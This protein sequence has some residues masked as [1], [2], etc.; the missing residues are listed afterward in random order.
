MRCRR[1]PFS[2][3]D[4]KL[5]LI[6]PFSLAKLGSALRG[7]TLLCLAALSLTL[8]SGCDSRQPALET[9][10]PPQEEIVADPVPQEPVT[11]RKMDYEMVELYLDGH[12]YAGLR[13]GDDLWCE[14]RDLAEAF[15][16]FTWQEA[17]EGLR[18][19]DG[20]GHSA[21]VSCRR[22]SGEERAAEGDEG[23]ILLN[24]DGSTAECWV[25]VDKLAQALSF[26]YLCDA[27][28]QTYYLSAAV[29]TSLI[30]SG[31]SVPVLMYH[32]VSD[33]TWGLE[34]LFLSPA[35][36]QDHL[37]FFAENGYQTIFFSDLA[38]LEDYDK[39]IL[40]TFDDGYDNNYSELFPILQEFGAKATIFVVTNSVDNNTT[41]MTSAQIKELAD[42]GIVDIQSHTVHHLELASLSEEDQ[43]W[44]MKES[45][46]MLARITGRIPYV[47]SYPAGKHNETTLAL[48]PEYYDFGLKSRDGLWTIGDNFFTVDRFP[49]YRGADRGDIQAMLP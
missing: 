16:G 5:P 47:L 29:D 31:R 45:Q 36:M 43:R 27:E 24:S 23:L 40:L 34:G 30:P 41:T 11:L 4:R 28:Y 22:L 39:P 3:L 15:A 7:C 20:Q 6:A 33:D 44:E 2:R 37:Q 49:V 42:S 38:H 35:D 10:P 1:K 48:G 9:A 17:A 13:Q 19:T 46:L 14:C 21:T 12:R 18:L 8:F 25:A 26:R 32:A